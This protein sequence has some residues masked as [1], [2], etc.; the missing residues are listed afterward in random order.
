M[1]QFEIESAPQPFGEGVGN[2][3]NEKQPKHEEEQSKEEEL[4]SGKEER[5]SEHEELQPKQQPDQPKHEE[6]QPKQEEQQPEPLQKG[7]S[8]DGGDELVESGWT[9]RP[10]LLEDNSILMVC[11]PVLIV[12]V[13]PTDNKR[14]E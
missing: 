2:L 10:G 5:Q 6:R 13:S 8:T 11:I 14:T 1:A 4:Q 7:Q 3:E 12:R 9:E